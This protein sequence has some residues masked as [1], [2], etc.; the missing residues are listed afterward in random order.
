MILAHISCPRGMRWLRCGWGMEGKALFFRI[1]IP[2][3][4][5]T[6]WPWTLCFICLLI[7]PL[8]SALATAWQPFAVDLL[9]L[10]SYRPLRR[11]NSTH[12]HFVL[13]PAT[14]EIVKQFHQRD[15]RWMWAPNYEFNNKPE[16]HICS[17]SLLKKDSSSCAECVTVDVGYHSL[18]G[19]RNLLGCMKL[20]KMPQQCFF[21]HFMI[22]ECH[23]SRNL[24]DDLS[25]CTKA[26]C[27]GYFHSSK[28][29]L[30]QFFAFHRFFA[31]LSVEPFFARN[32]VA[33]C[34]ITHRII[35]GGSPKSHSQRVLIREM[36]TSTHHWAFH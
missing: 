30:L 11:A 21:L 10:S 15:M 28:R 34:V 25:K 18:H 24:Q 20:D 26:P 29:N 2:K 5:S 17:R 12:E 32:S 13:T 23:S 6:S 27:I 36:M 31:L 19:S 35:H 22:S 1:Y 4:I 3:I 9:S 16:R 8:N 14:L 33:L 7:H